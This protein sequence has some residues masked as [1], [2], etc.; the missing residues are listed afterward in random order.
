MGQTAANVAAMPTVGS[1]TAPVAS[2]MSPGQAAQACMTTGSTG[3]ATGMESRKSS[4]K[5]DNED[6]IEKGCLPMLRVSHSCMI[7]TSLFSKGFCMQI[8]LVALCLIPL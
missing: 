3:Y 7:H 1:V 6:E 8:S 5:K 2:N 4:K